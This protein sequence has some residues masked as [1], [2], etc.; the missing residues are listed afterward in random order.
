MKKTSQSRFLLAFTLIELLVVI[1]IIAILASLL[2]PA[3]SKAKAKALRIK[4]TNNLKQIALAAHLNAGDHDGQF[5]SAYNGNSFRTA[6]S[7]PGIQVWRFFKSMENELVT[8]K[9]L[10]CPS[11]LNI[12]ASNFVRPGFADSNISY[13]AN[14]VADEAFPTRL[15]AADRNMRKY[16]VSGQFA[17]GVLRGM[18]TN[19]TDVGWGTQQHVSQGNI[20]LVDGS[21]QQTIHGTTAASLMN[22]MQT[23]GTTNLMAFPK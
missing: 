9:I 5:V 11:D 6:G 18:G 22:F 21:V 19:D 17:N 14:H 3:L 20:A 10:D 8:P 1:A 16:S 4:C 15:I 23:S 7:P 2:L 13:S 12:V